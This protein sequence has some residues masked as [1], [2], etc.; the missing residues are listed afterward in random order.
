LSLYAAC[1]RFQENS[2]LVLKG[3][4][5]P[6]LEKH[7]GNAVFRCFKQWN[8]K[9][10]IANSAKFAQNY[11]QRFTLPPQKLRQYFNET[12]RLPGGDLVLM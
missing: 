1:N 4:K 12:A 9:A 10:R 8:A 2:Q 3:A 7:V 5:S 11:R 6:L